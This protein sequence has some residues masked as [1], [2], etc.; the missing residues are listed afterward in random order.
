VEQRREPRRRRV[1]GSVQTQTGRADE[2]RG[3]EGQP[4]DA[5]HNGT[6]PGGTQLKSPPEHKVHEECLKG[7]EKER[8]GGVK[9][10]SAE[11]KPVL[12]TQYRVL[13]AASTLS[14]INPRHLIIA[15]QSPFRRLARRGR[16]N[17]F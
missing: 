17:R 7:R 12:S 5:K 9:R 13:R 11:E 10:S 15:R 6:S 8:G 1:V 14:R 16:R 4:A 2:D 3:Q